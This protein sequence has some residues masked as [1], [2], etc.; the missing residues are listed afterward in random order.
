MIPL[1]NHVLLALPATE[2]DLAPLYKEILFSSGLAQSNKKLIKKRHLVASKLL[3]T[4]FEKRG[5]QIQHPK[6]VTEGLWLNLILKYLR[7]SLQETHKIHQ[8]LRTHASAGRASRPP[9][10]CQQLRPKGLGKNI[11]QAHGQNQNARISC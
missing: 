4:C 7:N 3:S 10:A 5:L 8:T 2:K 11:K 1:Y 6:E 9:T